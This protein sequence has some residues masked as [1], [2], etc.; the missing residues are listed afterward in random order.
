SSRACSGA[1]PFPGS[2]THCLPREPPRRRHARMNPPNEMRGRRVA[3][4]AALACL[5][6]AQPAARVAKI[7]LLIEPSIDAAIERGVLAPFRR[8]MRQL[9]YGE[10]ANYVLTARS[11][12]GRNDAHEGAAVELLRIERDVDVTAFPSAAYAVKKTT[13]TVPI[14]AVGV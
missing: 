11:A 4:A 5:A 6:L 14:V 12:A 2:P 3:C 8:G 7:G 9:G 13:R 10:G 1:S